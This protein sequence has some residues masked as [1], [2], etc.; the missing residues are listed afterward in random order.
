MS[1][2]TNLNNN[3]YNTT[4]DTVTIAAAGTT[5]TAINL[6]GRELVQISLPSAISGAA[7]TFESSYDNVTYQQCVS[8]G[9]GAVT[10]TCA[11]AKNAVVDPGLLAGTRYIKLVRDNAQ[12]AAKIIN[13]ITRP[14]D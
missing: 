2:G 1:I 13:V 8:K 6:Q 3:I 12:A 5:S 7:F 11:A 14:I 9:G 4:I 10:V